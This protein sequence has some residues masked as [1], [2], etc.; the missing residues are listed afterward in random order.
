M[1]RILVV[2][3]K[4]S[5]RFIM[6]ALTK[7]KKKK[8]LLCALELCKTERII[9]NKIE[10]SWPFILYCGGQCSEMTPPP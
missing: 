6:W 8:K 3:T 4:V 1:D 7:K 10:F 5:H 9:F 2:E